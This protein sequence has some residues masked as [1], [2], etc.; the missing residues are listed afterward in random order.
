MIWDKANEKTQS[1]KSTW[2][3]N[4]FGTKKKKKTQNLLQFGLLINFK[5]LFI[6]K[7]ILIFQ[8]C[9]LQR[10][11]KKILLQLSKTPIFFRGRLSVAY[12]LILVA[13]LLLCCIF[14]HKERMW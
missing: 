6:L 12:C 9:F 3:V 13:F 8:V 10:R 2:V 14:I 5:G 7:V 4:N 11:R 1:T